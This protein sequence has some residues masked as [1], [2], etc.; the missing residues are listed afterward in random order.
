MVKLSKNINEG[1][2]MQQANIEDLKKDYKEN[3]IV[4][5][6]GAGFSI[7]FGVP[8]WRQLIEEITQKY[9]VG[10]LA[11]LSQAV[12]MNLDSGDFWE[13]IDTLKKFANLTEND[14]QSQVVEII[15]RKKNNDIED[16][17][18][19]YNDLKELN[20]STYL[21]TNYENLLF[22]YLQFDNI[23]IPLKDLNFN[24]QNLFSEQRIF[25]L[26]GI[27][28]NSGTI[29]ISKEGYDNL[30]KNRKYD[31]ILKLITGTKKILFLGF[32]FDDQF[33]KKLILDHKEIFSGNIY[34][35]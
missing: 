33:I 12:E 21:T 20:F 10:K 7:P 28:S 31:E 11:F 35:F 26:H 15:K 24:T 32:S 2:N 6:I 19:N 5:F 27:M 22:K 18:H 25:H 34:F 13:A 23:P 14:I 29:V 17:L 1:E 9:A 16:T 8:S 4:P 30:Y 3:N